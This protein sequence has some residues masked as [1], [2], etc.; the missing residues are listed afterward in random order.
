MPAFVNP[1]DFIYVDGAEI[2]I[3]TDFRTVL[4]FLEMWDDP[5]ILPNYKMGL[6]ADMFGVNAPTE[7]WEWINEGEKPEV[8]T[9]EKV[10]DFV[11]DERWI[12]TAFMAEYGVDLYEMP[13]LHWYKFKYMLESLSENCMLKQIMRI[14]ATDV[15]K[16]KN[17][18]E[19]EHMKKLQ[20]RYK[21]E[22]A[23]AQRL[24]ERMNEMGW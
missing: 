18:E 16:I 21:L 7:V 23:D 6:M 17:R 20:A 13:Y 4:T 19:R 3:N 24:L 11:K 22:D 12:Y 9:T 10:L 15:N 5:D 14:R 2:G 8:S 1:P